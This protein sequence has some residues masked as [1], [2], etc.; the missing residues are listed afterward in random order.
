MNKASSFLLALLLAPVLGCAASPVD[1]MQGSEKS[2]EIARP[3]DGSYVFRDQLIS[4]ECGLFQND[5]TS[6]EVIEVASSPDGAFF[7]WEESD[8]LLVTC[9]R[10]SN[11]LYEC[12]NPAMELPIGNLVMDADWGAD[13]G[14]SGSIRIDVGCETE[15][16]CKFLEEGFGVPMPCVS[17]VRYESAPMVAADFEAPTGEYIVSVG[18]PLMNSCGDAIS[19]GQFDMPGTFENSIMTMGDTAIPCEVDDQGIFQCEVDL[20]FGEARTASIRAEGAFV[21]GAMSAGTILAV[22]DCDS[23]A[24][25]CEAGLLGDLPCAATFELSAELASVTE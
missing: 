7:E 3:A 24:D 17:E 5:M 16:Q 21:N 9:A 23:D 22:I 6:P 20:P 4:D 19:D 13:G 18:E 2:D 12:D 14:F 8:G 1:N 15:E 10:L 25:D 11:G